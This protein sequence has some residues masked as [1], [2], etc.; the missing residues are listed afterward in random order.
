MQFSDDPRPKGFAPGGFSPAA[1]APALLTDLLELSCRAPSGTNTQPWTVWVLQGGALGQMLDATG[2][3]VGKLAAELG[4]PT[5]E[6]RGRFN[7]QFV[8][9]PGNFDWPGGEQGGDEFLTQAVAAAD[10]NLTRAAAALARYFRFYDAPVGLLFTI[11]RLL[12][13]G[14]L[15]DYGM[16]V[17]NI[18]LAAQ[19]R[20][21]R[22]ELQIGW[23]GLSDTVLAGI[24]A[25]PDDLLVAGMALGFDDPQQQ[26]V[27]RPVPPA[28]AASFTIWHA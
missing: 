11:S 3:E 22:T 5:A 21:L 27:A 18:V 1:V 20:S 4:N 19:A 16:F 14:S 7:Q 17:Q 2:P 13:S 26:P 15:L 12:G 23:K 6:S 25:A 10:G 28:G 8:R 24:G 9:H